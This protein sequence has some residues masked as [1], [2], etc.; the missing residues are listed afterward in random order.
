MITTDQIRFIRMQCG[1]PRFQSL[2][3][4]PG[5]P[6]ADVPPLT[7]SEVMRDADLVVA[8]AQRAGETV[9]SSEMYQRRAEVLRA[10]ID[11]LGL[12]GVS[13]DGHFAY[14]LGKLATYRVH[15]GSAAI[16]IEPGQ[17][18]CVVLANDDRIRHETI[19]R[20]IRSVPSR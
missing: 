15:L 19:L 1:A 6:L 5:V 9:L 18:L 11:D 2:W 10:L 8:V 14:V 4:G 12:P 20:Q 13:T 17:Y 7:L 3:S 16:H